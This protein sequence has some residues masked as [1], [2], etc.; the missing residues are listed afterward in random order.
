MIHQFFSQFFWNF[1]KLKRGDLISSGQPI[2]N[3]RWVIRSPILYFKSTN[4]GDSNSFSLNRFKW[5]LHDFP[6]LFSIFWNF[7]KLRRGDLISWWKPILQI[8]W[9]TWSPFLS[10]NSTNL[11]D[12]NSSSFIRFQWVLHDSIILFSIFWNFLNLM[13]GDLI[14]WLEP[15]LQIGWTIWSPLLHFN[16]RN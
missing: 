14:S 16:F 9:I 11:R 3:N 1:L 7:L 8:G 5:V 15:I 4:L 13:S 10:F 6:E 12:S 2:L